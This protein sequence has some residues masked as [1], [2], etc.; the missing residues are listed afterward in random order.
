M[1]HLN[2]NNIGFIILFFIGLGILLYPTISN[3][4]NNYRD[5]ILIESYDKKVQKVDKTE[6]NKF[7]EEAEDYNKQ[8][9]IQPVPDAF[10]I[11]DGIK[12]KTYESVLNMESDGMM[13]YIDIPS[14]KVNIPIYHYTTDDSLS[15][16]AGHLFGSALPV[17]G[18]GTHTVVSAHR[19]LPSAELFTNLPL[20]KNGDY[21]YFHILDRVIAYK[22]DQILTVEPH[23][24]ESLAGE[25][26]IDYAT[27]ITCTPYGVNTQRL[28]V[29]GHRVAYDKDEHVKESERGSKIDRNHLLIQALCGLIGLI[30][31]L[32][33]F[34][35]YGFLSRK[36]KR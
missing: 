30:L 21:F 34:A 33:I 12:D 14:I 22:V 23:E 11:R 5:N 6:I 24:V 9:G 15:K 16:G 31:A 28:L 36:R 27:L 26:G 7:W 1:K 18:E 10:S 2:K 20:L 13:G 4:W 35:I 8:L 29:R 32:V 17:G 25:T 19:G 3:E